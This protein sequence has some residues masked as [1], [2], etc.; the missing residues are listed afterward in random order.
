MGPSSANDNTHMPASNAKNPQPE[1]VHPDC[2][3]TDMEHAS[4]RLQCAV[5]AIAAI[6]RTERYE[7]SGWQLG[8]LRLDACELHQFM[9]LGQPGVLFIDRNKSVNGW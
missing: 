1:Q 4:A 5:A 9:F 2:P 7:I 3:K 6:R 8:S